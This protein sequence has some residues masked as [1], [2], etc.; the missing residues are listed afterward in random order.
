VSSLIGR[1]L[2]Q[3]QIIS[4]LGKGGMATVY[5]G[6][7][8]SIGR[9]VAVKVLPPHPSL[10]ENFIQRFELEA[11]TIGTLQH[12]HILSLYDYGNEDDILYLVM[13]YADGG[14]LADL[15]SDGTPDVRTIERV[16]RESASALDY[17]HRRG[18]VHR[19]IKPANI[20]MDSEGHS[21]LA[22]FGI[23]K[24]VSEGANLTGTNIV[25][26]PAYMAP[27]Q[28][29]GLEIDG[30]ADIYSLGCLMFEL[31]AGKPP[32]KADSPMQI[33]LQHMNADVP[34]ICEIRSDLPS[35]LSP[36]FKTVMAKEPNERYQTAVD[37]AEAFSEAL[38]SDSASLASVRAETPLFA[39][40][41][42]AVTTSTPAS[43][44]TMPHNTVAHD[45]TNPPSSQQIPQTIIMRDSTNPMILLGGFGL[46]AVLIIAGAVVIGSLLLNQQ[47]NSETNDN[48]DAV[49]LA[50]E[51]TG[52]QDTTQDDNDTTNDNT[53]VQQVPRF[54]TL[55]YS[56]T[57]T[58]G[59][60][61]TLQLTGMQAPS[62][63]NRYAA[64]LVN[65]E[66]N[67]TVALGRVTLDAL[68][69]GV[70][71]Y[72]DEDGRLLPAHFNAVVVTEESE[73]GDEPTGDVRYS[74]YVPFEVMQ[75]LSH[76]LVSDEENG[77]SGGSLLDGALTEARFATQHAGL[78]ARATSIGGVRTHSEHTINILNGTE[79]DYNGD[80]RGSN[81][82]RGVGLYF[83][84]DEI[85]TNID[86]ALV[87]D[88]ID[89]QINAEYI[90]VCV[91]N[92]RDWADAIIALELEM[93]AADDVESI[94]QQAN[95]ST[96]LA[97]R[98]TTGIDQ[99]ENGTIEPFEGECGLNQIADYG[100][101]FGNVDILEGDF[102]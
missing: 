8:P 46:L 42:P 100:V 4:L 93:L 23:V 52:N 30:R 74:G 33:I 17:A 25:G 101:L 86:N 89:V 51:A 31:L 62:G 48:G 13:Q 16:L 94:E 37:F 92:A 90:R 84:L 53:N 54:G 102:R 67:I 75:S 38:H 68:G 66:D 11:R 44:A 63:G 24:M 6:H 32:Y 40:T 21:F 57:D 49:A 88:Y 99:N 85:K 59:D 97:A 45:P 96:E 81:P 78:A 14:T 60:T 22:D 50:T 19:D 47:N 7:Q 18:V 73:I 5:K 39:G 72:T 28:G 95:E 27:E 71:V 10:D 2:G 64:W 43:P 70:L 69:D 56:T 1:T 98:I 77:L 34:D 65:T 82:G 83:F 58:L 61:L 3:Y 91:L 36:V 76:I 20:L 9:E 35:A 15:A 26:T 55:R 12:P 41:Q 29:Q 87:G 80:G 79:E